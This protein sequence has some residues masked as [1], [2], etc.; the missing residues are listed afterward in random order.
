MAGATTMFCRCSSGRRTST[1][2]PTV[3]RRRRTAAHPVPLRAAPPA[4]RGQGGG[5]RGGP[6]AQRRPQW[7]VD[8]GRGVRPCQYQGRRAPQFVARV[9]RPDSRRRKPHNPHR[10]PRAAAAV[11]GGSLRR[12]RGARTRRPQGDDPAAARGRLSAGASTAPKLLML[13]GVG[14]GR[15][16]AELG[17][18]RPSADLPGVGRISD[19]VSDPLVYAA[20]AAT[21]RPEP[22]GHPSSFHDVPFCFSRSGLPVPDMQS[23]IGQCAGLL[24]WLR[25]PQEGLTFSRTSTARPRAGNVRLASADPAAAPL[26][27]P[28]YMQSC[29]DRRRRDARAWS[30][31]RDVAAPPPCANGSARSCTPAPE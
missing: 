10:A 24:G 14:P 3:S 27:D 30:G 15:D 7:R 28:D 22:L 19:H 11:R 16:L 29:D 5:D 21:R 9:R 1:E 26:I 23:M 25:G 2:A 6:A 13:S 20:D 4:G 18:R 31:S 12:R 17:I 8:R